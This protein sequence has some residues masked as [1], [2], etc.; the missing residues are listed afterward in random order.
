M[1]FNP[2]TK[3]N[4]IDYESVVFPK[5]KDEISINDNIDVILNNGIFTSSYDKFKTFDSLIGNKT[6]L[7][8]TENGISE[9][10][11][12]DIKHYISTALHTMH[13][14]FDFDPYTAGENLI[15]EAVRKIVA[16]G[17]KPIAISIICCLNFSK[18]GE[19]SRFELSRKG[20][21]HAAKKLKIKILNLDVTND[22]KL[23]SVSVLTIGKAK[24]S[25][26]IL[27]PYFNNNHF[28]LSL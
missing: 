15:N 7:Y 3:V 1:I 26:K 10:W 12:N 19:V 22:D 13:L 6:S 5:K 27:V 24:K 28:T 14:Q 16:M 17:H 2:I 21:F 4:N 25:N 8:K 18:P 9:L 23:C 11:F 20:I